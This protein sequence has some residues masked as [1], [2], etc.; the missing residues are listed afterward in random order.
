VVAVIRDILAGQDRSHIK[1]WQIRNNGDIYN[2]IDNAIKERGR[3]SFRHK[4]TKGHATDDDIAKGLSSNHEKY[5]NDQSDK[6]AKQSVEIYKLWIRQYDIIQVRRHKLYT[7]T[8]KVYHQMIYQ[9]GTA[10]MDELKRI[11]K[12]THIHDHDAHN[13]RQINTKNKKY[14]LNQLQ[15]TTHG[16]TYYMQLDDHKCNEQFRYWPCCGL[17]AAT[18]K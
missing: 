10:F 18:V 17:Y 4:W 6:Q 8:T 2:E 3:E 5:Y 16:N 15:Y 14:L 12:T 1:P 13:K 7:R 9:T 11:N